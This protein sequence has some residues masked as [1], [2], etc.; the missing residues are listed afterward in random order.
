MFK[1][2]MSAPSVSYEEVNPCKYVAHVNCVRPF[3]LVFSESQHTLWK[4]YVDN[5]EMSPIIVNSL[6]NGFLVNKTGNF[7]V[8]IYFT[9]QDVADIGLLISVG[10]TIFV[11]AVLLVKSTLAK[12][13]KHFVLKGTQFRSKALKTEE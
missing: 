13:L 11:V 3:L 4:A 12:K 1:S 2:D 5:N 8:M 7:D 6:A 9:G 10:S